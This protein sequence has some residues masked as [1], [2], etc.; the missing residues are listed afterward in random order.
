MVQCFETLYA[1]RTRN[2]GNAREVNN[3][4]QKVKENQSHRIIDLM[5]G[6]GRPT[7]EQLLTLTPEDF[8]L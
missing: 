8:K 7:P 1:N 3:V 5:M 4:F 2:F 6:G